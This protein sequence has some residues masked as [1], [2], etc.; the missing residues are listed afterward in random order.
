MYH[1]SA[2]YP[3]G[4]SRITILEKKLKFKEEECN[5]LWRDYEDALRKI[6]DL[7]AYRG[8]KPDKNDLLNS[9]IIES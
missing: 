2:P 9:M 8:I 5:Q 1:E 3:H 7:E 4:N 6:E